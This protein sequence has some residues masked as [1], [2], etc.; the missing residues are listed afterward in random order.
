[1]M[2]KATRVAAIYDVHGNLPA[3]EAVLSDIERMGP[4]L[5]VV[6]GGRGIGSDARGGPRPVGGDE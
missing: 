2:E 5:I 4:D 6:G 3:L 1:M